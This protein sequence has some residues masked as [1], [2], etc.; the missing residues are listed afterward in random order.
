MLYSTAVGSRQV[1]SE[2]FV[3]T[4]KLPTVTHWTYYMPISKI[5]EFWLFLTIWPWTWVR[6]TGKA[7]SESP[8]F[9]RHFSF[10]NQAISAPIH[11]IFH[12][13][14]TKLTTT[15]HDGNPTAWLRSAAMADARWQKR[16]APCLWVS[17]QLR[18]AFPFYSAGS[19]WYR[20]R[21]AGA[22]LARSIHWP[23][24]AAGCFVRHRVKRPFRCLSSLRIG[25]SV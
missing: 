6:F 19:G 21:S 15:H 3:T 1:N 10:K 2:D 20:H 22:W 4:V 24:R 11:R 23:V 12:M 8:H 17:W 7:M 18:S 25:A 5:A 13:F 9:R 16:W 14:Y